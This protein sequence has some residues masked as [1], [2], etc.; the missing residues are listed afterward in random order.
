MLG[1]FDR[2]RILQAEV[3]VAEQADACSHPNVPEQEPVENA[4]AIDANM[5]DSQDAIENIWQECEACADLKSKHRQL[6]NR[7]QSL[8]QKLRTGRK[9]L[10]SSR[11]KGTITVK[12]VGTIPISPLPRINVGISAAHST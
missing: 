10:F 5:N 7:V 4:V 1:N 11:R 12:S 3:T 6:K 9:Q 2:I 8:Q